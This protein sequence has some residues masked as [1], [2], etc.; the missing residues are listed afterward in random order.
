MEEKFTVTE[1]R[2]FMAVINQ[3]LSYQQ[4]SLVIALS[5][6]LGAGK[7][8]FTQVLGQALGIKEPVTSPTFTIMKQYPLDHPTYNKLVHIDAYRIESPQETEP[9]H[10]EEL[11][12]QT[13]QV[14]CVEWP[15]NISAIIPPNAIKLKIDIIEQETRQVTIEKN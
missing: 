11:L 8:T 5:G 15:E 9:L 10:I 3:L 7:T 6:D 1:P 2:D 14:V 13:H 4:T 12:K